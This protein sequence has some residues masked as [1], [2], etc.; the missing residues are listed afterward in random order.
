MRGG[1]ATVLAYH[2][3]SLEGAALEEGD[4]ALPSDLFA[5]QMELLAAQ[6]RS[7]VGL[8][9]LT[10]GAFPQGAV[11]LTFDDG[12]E[13]DATV[14]LPLLR[15]L[16]FPAAFFVNPAWLGEPGRL[17]WDQVREL[18]AAGMHVGSHGF[19]HTLLDGLPLPELERQ[20]ALSK[21]LLEEGLGG[22][23]DALSLP[24]GT[25][26]RRALR[27]ARGLGY[28]VVL[29]SQPGLVRSGARP[30]LVP[31]YAVRR[32]DGL[33]GFRAVVEQRPAFRIAHALRYGA[34]RGLRSILGQGAYVRLRES[35]LARQERAR[36]S[37]G[38]A[39]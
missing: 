11:L 8:P 36:G 37:A 9:A 39:S 10:E 30:G 27:V 34:L 13:T 15:A 29:G 22:P 32:G 12:C 4:Y 26:G 16:R 35:L 1:R 7:V 20:L 28:R 5:R 33:A 19:D 18:A 21:S 17:D 2:R 6:G 23:V 25:G 24:G 31:R 3:V 38:R 14:V